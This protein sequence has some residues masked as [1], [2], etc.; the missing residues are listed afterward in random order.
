MGLPFTDAAPV[1]AEQ[2]CGNPD[3]DPSIQCKTGH[4][5]IY[6]PRGRSICESGRKWITQTR[7]R[8]IIAWHTMAVA[9]LRSG[10][11][12]WMAVPHPPEY[13]AHTWQ[14]STGKW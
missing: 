6:G 3:S 8:A 10:P 5:R 9:G 1:R 7:R 4:Q 14:A 12:I 2:G 11:S 13:A